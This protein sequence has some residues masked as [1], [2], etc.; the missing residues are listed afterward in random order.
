MGSFLKALLPI[1]YVAFLSIAANSH[2]VSLTLSSGNVIIYGSN[3]LITA[4][5]SNSLNFT[6]ISIDN[7]VVANALTANTAAT[8]NLKAYAAIPYL[9]SN[10]IAGYSYTINAISTNSVNLVPLGSAQGSSGSVMSNT[11]SITKASPP[12]DISVPLDKMSFAYGTFTQLNQIPASLYVNN[13]LVFNTITGIHNSTISGFYYP[14]D[15]AFSPSGA[16]AY[17]VNEDNSTI[18]IVNTSTNS[19]VSLIS[20]FYYPT[21]AAI[22]P[23]GAYAYVTNYYNGTIK[24]VNTST[25]SIVSIISGFNVPYGVAFSPDGAYAYVVNGGNDTVSIVNTSNRSIISNIRGFNDPFAVAFSPNGAYAYITDESTDGYISVVNTSTKSIVSN[26]TGFNGSTGVAFSPSGAYAYVTNYDDNNIRIVNTSTNSIV[27][28]IPGFN[29]PMGVAF[30][31]NGAYAYVTNNHNRTVSIV[32]TGFGS[33]KFSSAGTYSLVANTIGNANYTS[34]SIAIS[35]KVINESIT[36]NTSATTNTSY[37]YNNRAPS[38]TAS[39]KSNSLSGNILNLLAFDFNSGTGNVITYN[40]G[41]SLKVQMPSNSSFATAGNYIYTISSNMHNDI[42]NSA[43]TIIVYNAIVPK[44]I[45][46]SILKARPPLSLTAPKNITYNGSSVLAYYGTVTKLNQIPAS[47]YA[48]NALVSNT[49]TGIHNSTISGFADVSGVAFSPSGSYAYALNYISNGYISVVNTSTKSIIAAIHGFFFPIGVAFSP[50]GSYAYVTNYYNDTVGIVNTSTRSIISNIHGF[51]H[52]FAVAISPSGSYAYVTNE[53]SN[54]ISVVNTSTNSIV[55]TISGLSYPVGVAFSPSGSYAYV[56]G[57]TSNGNIIIVNTSTNSIVSTIPG[58][59]TSFGIAFSPNGA[60][61]YVT[62]YDNNDISVVDTSNNSIISNIPGF[63]VPFG[64]AFSP[65]GAYAYVAEDNF[66]GLTN[67]LNTG[68]D[69]HKFSAAGTYLLTA[70][71]IG[72]ENYTANTV[73]ASFMIAK[74]TPTLKLTVCSN[75][76]YNGSEGC[77]I[78]GLINSLGNQLKGYLYINGNVVANSS[79]SSNTIAFT[80]YEGAGNYSVVFNTTGNENYTAS[81]I[82]KKFSI[83]KASPKITFPIFP[84]NFVYNGSTATVKAEISTYGNQLQASA[85]INNAIVSSFYTSNVFAVG[86]AAGNYIITANTVG[87]G[88]YIAASVSNTLTIT[89]AP[90]H[91]ASSST[92]NLYITDNVNSTYASNRSVIDVYIINSSNQ[93]KVTSFHY[94]QQQ[95]PAALSFPSADTA[96]FSFACS[97]AA[98]GK[99]YVSADNYG[100]LEFTK[101]GTN[102]TTTGGSYEAYYLETTQRTTTTTSSTSTISTTV[103]TTT[104]APPSISVTSGGYSVSLNIVPKELSEVAIAP[105]N[106]LIGINSNY[107]ENMTERITIRNVTSTMPP[108]P[109][110]YYVIEGFNITVSKALP[111]INVTF[112][113]GCTMNPAVIRPLRFS[114]G[115]WVPIANYSLNQSGCSVAFF[116]SPNHEVA[117]ATIQKAENSTIAAVATTTIPAS[118]KYVPDYNEYVIVIAV[119][120]LAIMIIAYARMRALKRRQNKPLDQ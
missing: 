33:D 4:T 54:T 85:F 12:L 53:Y 14:T 46:I 90:V 104:I 71:T 87:N 75:Y 38:I 24:I 19:I 100:L 37:I 50:S 66:Y 64:I 25:N 1:L 32:N 26:I 7:I 80:A 105:L 95:L 59:N 35:F 70:N 65:N 106:L 13:A 108:L 92:S 61:A 6:E 31:P 58:F 41:N 55:S 82:K 18:S 39:L 110:G 43:N 111:A 76:T 60:Y 69:S 89:P 120:V 96:N 36:I 28:T 119:V 91:H 5:P 97:F 113:Y 34:N 116:A 107:T 115:T 30:S 29:G 40:N 99:Y 73:S 16:Y 48:N 67:V 52:P 20:G 11:I 102:Y 103:P 68:F 72:N 57:D 15:V 3:D 78:T 9:N 94:Y 114:N 21:S 47:L 44:S 81:S 98:G 56:T 27:S 86:P 117:I 8:F 109:A 22:S 77:L 88:N 118:P 17:V 79:S 83:A 63:D 2:A 42:L 23:N 10:V 51:N 84:Q 112:S 62:N 49:I 101:C 45:D 93:S 74:A